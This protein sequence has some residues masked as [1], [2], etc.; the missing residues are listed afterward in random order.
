MTL[1]EFKKLKPQLE[2][3]FLQI[4]K[5][6]EDEGVD[7]LSKNYEQAI[8]LLKNKI[9][10]AKGLTMEEYENF[11]NLLQD[12]AEELANL[13]SR[14]KLSNISDERILLLKD[15]IIGDLK[16]DISALD[17]KI[18]TLQNN[19]K[20]FNNINNKIELLKNS[21]EAL[22]K[23]KPLKQKVVNKEYKVIEKVD[24]DDKWIKEKFKDAKN[25]L[26]LEVD[27]KMSS[28]GK[29][30][31]NATRDL[32]RDMPAFRRLG[33]GLQAQIDSIIAGLRADA[34]NLSSQ[35]NGITQAFTLS[36]TYR[37]VIALSLN[38]T[39]LVQGKEF[40]FDNDKTITLTS[41]IPQNG[42]EL[43]AICV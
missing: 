3:L 33:I 14:V 21:L 43:W 27:G 40:N 26:A 25:E 9:L 34:I 37:A 31:E 23:V 28:F 13:F 4:E 20:E 22:K 29:K 42:E 35:C 12:D 24:Y 17:S 2:K 16:S 5:E 1:Q 39:I 38:G 11:N 10:T 32:V 15:K 18:L 36:Q 41:I 7:I 8:L 6:L 30:L 19:I